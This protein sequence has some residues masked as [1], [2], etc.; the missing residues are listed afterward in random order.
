[1]NDV[2]KAKFNALVG[3]I[4]R[5]A[6][7]RTLSALVYRIRDFQLSEDALQDAILVAWKTW[8]DKG[9]PAKPQAWLYQT[10]V[11]KAIDSIRRRENFEAKRSDIELLGTLERSHP[12]IS[13]EEEIPDERLR[14]IFTCCHPSLDK[15]SSVALTLRAVGGLHTREIARAFLTE[16]TTMGQRLTRAKRKI[17][18]AGIPYRVPP[19]E[20][21]MERFEAVLSVIYLIFNEGYYATSGP[22]LLRHE[23]CE[24]AI[25]LARVVLQLA[26]EETEAAGLLSLMLLHQARSS[27]RSD[28]EGNFAPLDSQDRSKWDQSLISEGDRI[29]KQALSKQ[30]PG[31][32]QIQAAIS[33]IHCKSLNWHTTDWI[34]ISALYE[35]LYRLS[36]SDVVRLNQIVAHSWVIGPEGALIKLSTIESPL[37]Q[38]QPF[39]ATKA[40]FFRRLGRID[41][42][43]ASYHTALELSSN[44]SEINFIEHRIAELRSES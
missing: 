40:D 15:K 4:V 39:H 23:L 17:R 42:A 1:M 12:A 22:A 11:R 3:S 30:R 32:Y 13:E 20:L 25:H 19:P 34:Q 14:L 8:P 36:P 43:I 16:E 33:A 29:L 6:W 28:L 21:W 37:Q 44:D 38:Y 27:T 18:D 7:G 35:E 2:P 24:E 5:E 9:V 26:P 41:E 31:P 10:A